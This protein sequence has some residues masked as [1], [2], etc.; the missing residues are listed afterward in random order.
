VYCI[1]L[2]QPYESITVRG[3][4]VKR[5]KAATALGTGAT[6]GFKTHTAILDSFGHDPRG[7]VI[8]SVPQGVI[9]EYATVIAID[10]EG[11]L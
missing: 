6:L 8:V 3:M 9:D 1:S 4:P 5:I 11:D 2:A 7:D 10:F